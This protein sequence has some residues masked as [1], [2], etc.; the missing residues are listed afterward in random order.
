VLWCAGCSQASVFSNRRVAMV[1]T[2]FYRSL[3][4]SFTTYPA[5]TSLGFMVAVVVRGQ[6]A[7]RAFAELQL[8][9]D[10]GQ[11]FDSE[12]TALTQAIAVARRLIDDVLAA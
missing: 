4:V 2:C 1:Q 6:G 7:R 5:T 11:P 10:R 9:D 3:M 8:S 12:A